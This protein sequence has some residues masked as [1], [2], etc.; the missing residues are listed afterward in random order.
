MNEVAG[1]SEGKQQNHS[2]LF[3]CPLSFLPGQLQEHATS[4]PASKNLIKKIP[5]WSSQEFGF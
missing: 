2:L 4:L 1:E 3:S 5:H